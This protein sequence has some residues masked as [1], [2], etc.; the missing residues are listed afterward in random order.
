M[1][2]GDGGARHSAPGGHAQEHP[3][4][5]TLDAYPTKSLEP[6]CMRA[7]VLG[8]PGMV[9]LVVMHKGILRALCEGETTYVEP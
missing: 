8:A 1:R 9:H 5:R 3:R 6:L 7:E 4:G 2:R